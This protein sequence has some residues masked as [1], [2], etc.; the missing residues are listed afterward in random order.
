DA[1]IAARD[2]DALRTVLADEYEVV[3][4]TTGVTYDR[5]GELSS[6]RAL[7]RARD[8][9]FQHEPLATLGDSLALCRMSTSARGFVGRKFDVAAYEREQVGVVEV[10]AQER[11]RRIEAFA[12]D[13]LGDAVVRLYER[14]TE[15]LPDGPARDRAA[16]TT[17]SVAGFLGA[18]SLDGVSAGI[19]PDVDFVDHR[20]VGLPSSRGREAYVHSLGS[21][22]ESGDDLVNRRDDVLALRPDSFVFRVTTLG[23]ERAGGGAFER[24]LLLLAIF[25]ADGLAN[26]WEFFD[27]TRDVEALARFDELTS[28][29][30]TPTVADKPLRAADGRACRVRPNAATANVAAVDAPIAARDA[31]AVAIV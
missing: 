1:A 5:Q 19:A 10:D 8:P 9:R 27:P 30:A 23:T 3:D 15:L 12:T 25:D 14:Y 22:F 28:G 6:L 16:A 24:P 26:H 11:H 13:R 29:A 17:R 18:L 31:D 2:A 7:L 4:R 21:L 20:P